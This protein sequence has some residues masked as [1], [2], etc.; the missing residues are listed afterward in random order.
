MS[1]TPKLDIEYIARL[2]RLKLTDQEKKRFSRQLTSVLDH[3][4]KLKELDLQGVPPTF[5]TTGITDGVREDRVEAER[6]L[7]SEEALSN[8]GRKVRG[9]FRIPKV[10]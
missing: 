4:E 8:A 10:L 6:V 1:K 7:T 2:A 5:Q 9:F 3:V